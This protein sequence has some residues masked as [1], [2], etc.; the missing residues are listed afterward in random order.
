MAT[1]IEAKAAE[2]GPHVAPLKL[3]R[4]FSARPETVFKA[5]TATEHVKRWYS[6]EGSTI[7]EAEV[8]PRP[9]GVF[10]FRMLFPDGS[11]HWTRGTFVEVTPSTRLVL[12]LDA[13]DAQGR[14]MFRCVTEVDFA[15]VPGGAQV[16]LVQSFRNVDP[17]IA[18]MIAE[19]G[20]GG[21]G[22]TLHRLDTELLQMS[23][24]AETTERSAAHAT[25]HLTRTYPAPVERVW[26]AL[27]MPE[28]KLKWFGSPGEIELLER[29]MDIR[30]GGTER[31]KGRWKSG[32]VSDF[33]AVYHDLIPNQRLIYSYVMRL[34]DR[35]I[36]VSLA[37]LE[38]RGEGAKTTLAVTEQGAF[39]DGYDDAGAREH[40]TGLLLDALGAS[41]AD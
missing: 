5:W 36:S 31:L 35:M 4:T 18:G 15:E 8:D 24:A 16:N 6:P 11:E 27:T 22:S 2:S 1:S 28:A 34:D 29:R 40:G 3:S 26:K 39:L 13:F 30:V 38:L 7:P 21:W 32:M 14:L 23:G 41:L 37:T 25:F 9:G 12:D 17:A 10:A 33:E 19:H 20:A